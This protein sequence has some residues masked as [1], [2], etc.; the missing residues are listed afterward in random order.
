LHQYN[1]FPEFSDLLFEKCH[2]GEREW[3]CAPIN[4]NV[5]N[6]FTEQCALSSSV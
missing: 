3:A 6:M 4:V 5:L 2:V 1:R